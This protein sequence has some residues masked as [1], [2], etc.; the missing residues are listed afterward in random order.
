MCSPT[1]PRESHYC[2]SED[3]QEKSITMALTSAGNNA[4]MKSKPAFYRVWLKA[5]FCVCIFYD[6]NSERGIAD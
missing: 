3:L 2:D 5:V 1:T 6:S 4:E